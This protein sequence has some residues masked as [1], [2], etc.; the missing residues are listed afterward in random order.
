MPATLQTPCTNRLGG[1]TAPGCCSALIPWSSVTLPE[2]WDLNKHILKPK[3]N[4]IGARLLSFKTLKDSLPLASREG[5]M[6]NYCKISSNVY[7]CSTSD[8][9]PKWKC[10]LGSNPDF[11]LS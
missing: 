5:D 2:R 7:L 3:P 4:Y 8:D 9:Q 10:D 1:R 11:N 6:Q